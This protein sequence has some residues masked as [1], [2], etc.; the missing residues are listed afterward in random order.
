MTV[1]FKKSTNLSN[2]YQQKYAFFD[3]KNPAVN[4][5]LSYLNLNIFFYNTGLF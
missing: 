1:K 4:S 5:F 2:K 3:K